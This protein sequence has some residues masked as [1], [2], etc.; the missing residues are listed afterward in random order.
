MKD[1]EQRAVVIQRSVSDEGP[2]GTVKCQSPTQ[3]FGVRE[4]VLRR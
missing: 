3:Q 4:K 1:E 2:T